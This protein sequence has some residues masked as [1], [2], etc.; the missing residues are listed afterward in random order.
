M[1]SR[2]MIPP[3]SPTTVSASRSPEVQL[4]PRALLPHL[5]LPARTPQSPPQALHPPEL[6]APPPVELPQEPLL[7]PAPLD[8]APPAHHPT[9]TL[10]PAS[11]PHWHSPS[12]LS[13]P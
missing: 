7:Q 11:P 6:E 2:S 3:M 13:Q 10:A 1:L 5:P 9:P 8:P 12:W 4:L